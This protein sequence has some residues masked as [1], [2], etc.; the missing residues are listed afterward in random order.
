[1]PGG[2]PIPTEVSLNLSPTKRFDV[3]DSSARVEAEF[4][5][6][7]RRYQRALYCSLHTTAGYLGHGLSA[8]LAAGT[9]HDGLQRFFRAFGVLF[10]PGAPYG[11]DQIHLRDDLTDEQREVEPRNADSHLTFIASGMSNCVTHHNERHVPA[12]FVDLDGT[13][14]GTRRQRTTAVLAYD[15]ERVVQRVTVPVPVSRHP[16]DSINLG[17]PRLGFIEQVDALLKRS[18]IEQGRIDLVLAP[19]EGNAGLTVNEYETFLMQH[20]LIEVLRNPLKFAAQKGRHM[21]DDPLAIPGKTVNY[22]T[23]DFVHVFNSLMEAFRVD[24]SVVERLLAKVIAL[25]ARRFL[26]VKRGISFLASDPDRQ[27]SARLV[28]GTYQSPILLQWGVAPR[29]SRQVEVSL[30]RFD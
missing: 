4:G 28:R 13:F 1:M 25:P 9:E 8:R 10:P 23:Y 15:G 29:Q 17:D 12:Y 20:D 16:I 18:G 21:L 11:H 14:E 22:A 19:S 7:L 5:D 24:Q 3:I 30:V 2:E 26:R 6:L 27:G